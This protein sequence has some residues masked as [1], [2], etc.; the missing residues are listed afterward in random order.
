MFE[1]RWFSSPE[2]DVGA[3]DAALH[4]LIV[5]NDWLPDPDPVTEAFDYVDLVW[6]ECENREGYSFAYAVY[7]A[8]GGY[9]GCCYLYP[10]GRRTPLSPDLLH[11]DVDVSWWVTPDAYARGCYATLYAALRRWVVTDFPFTDPHYSN[12][13]IPA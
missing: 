6:H 4:A 8:G 7:D 11:H 10:M 9:Q 2:T 3:A 13:E 12:V 1:G 5:E